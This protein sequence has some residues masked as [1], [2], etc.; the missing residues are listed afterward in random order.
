LTGFV[1]LLLV[2]LSFLFLHIPYRDPVLVIP[3]RLCD[4]I[5]AGA[6]ELAVL[7]EE[8]VSYE[9]GAMRSREERTDIL[10]G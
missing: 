10:Y 2:N 8:A 7:S 9:F 6:A 1:Q 5:I 3:V 4:V